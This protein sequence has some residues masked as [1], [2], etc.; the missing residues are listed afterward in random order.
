MRKKIL[1]YI[2]IFSISLL[3]SFLILLSY[4]IKQPKGITL[5]FILITALRAALL[6]TGFTILGFI[7]KEIFPKGLFKKRKNKKS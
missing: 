7:Y 2:I 4:S 6:S 5:E 3:A 1:Y